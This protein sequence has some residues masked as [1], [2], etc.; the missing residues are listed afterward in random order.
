[1]W[2]Q[3]ALDHRPAHH[4]I[5]FISA[6][7]S[8][9]WHVP[10][11]TAP[12]DAG[13]EHIGWKTRILRK[14]SALTGYAIFKKMHS[15]VGYDLFADLQY[16]VLLP[17][18][19]V[20]DVGANTGQTALEVSKGFPQA[21]I[22]SFEPV[23][24]SFRKLEANTAALPNVHRTHAALGAQA[25]QREIRLYPDDESVANSLN[26]VAMN[27]DAAAR[28][29]TIQIMTGDAYCKEKGIASFDLLKI[30]TEGFELEVVKGFD[31][32]LRA[33]KIGA[34]YCEVSFNPKDHAHTYI[35]DL[36]DLVLGYGYT[37]Y[38]IYNI[39]N[40]AIKVGRSY[41]NVL[42]VSPESLARLRC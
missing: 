41:A 12:D 16:R 28:T 26:P 4:T 31:Q 19:T 23:A 13:M 34:I 29:E 32:L 7:D 20:L 1:M 6:N 21:V 3:V 40:S 39:S 37:F 2:Q 11:K 36:N 25:E 38:G 14:I 33:G 27:P 15:P 8:R 5:V 24:E 9:L 42:Y 17:M 30:D 22:H 18:R 35:N 10:L